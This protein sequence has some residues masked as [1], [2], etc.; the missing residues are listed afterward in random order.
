VK[1]KT[2]A[3]PCSTFIQDTM[4]QLLSESAEF[5]RGCDE[6]ILAYFFFLDTVYTHSTDDKRHQGISDG[7]LKRQMKTFLFRTLAVD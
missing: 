1:W 2:S 3:V 6:N 7:Q 4:Y 5:C